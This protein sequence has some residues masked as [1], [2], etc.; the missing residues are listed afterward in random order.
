MIPNVI[1]T[2]P[3]PVFLVYARL[4]EPSPPSNWIGPYLSSCLL[5]L[6]GTAFLI[7]RKRALNRCF[8]G[9]NVYFF[10]GC[11]GLL[12]KQEWLN[13]LMGE[14]EAAGMLAS[15][16]IT[17]ICYTCFSASGF[18]GVDGADR[19]DA[20]KYSLVLLVTAFLAFI[21]SLFFLGNMWLAEVV[22][23]V[24]LFTV[25]SRLKS[26]LIKCMQ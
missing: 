4:I 19:I 3:L 8:V 13:T 5:A 11:I 9:I 7:W 18:L 23:F 20:R 6:I 25:Q 17:G 10:V 16:F 2:I 22:P 1:E 12:T 14:V 15:I 21:I 26:K 24:T